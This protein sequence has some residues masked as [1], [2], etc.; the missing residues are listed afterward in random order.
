[1]GFVERSGFL[2]TAP[3]PIHRQC[4][5]NEA[6]LSP[7]RGL[8]RM[9]GIDPAAGAFLKMPDHLLASSSFNAS[10]RIRRVQ[11]V[12][13]GENVVPVP[14]S[15]LV[16]WS[17]SPYIC[18]YSVAALD[19]RDPGR[20]LFSDEIG[21]DRRPELTLTP[22]SAPDMEVV[23]ATRNEHAVHCLLIKVLPHASCP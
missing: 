8:A 19:T 1:M 14:H 21:K 3:H 4:K 10:R 11:C 13:G 18:G 16:P 9:R 6:S 23:L 7:Y 15:C 5:L 22:A 17:C 20:F 2:H 12:T